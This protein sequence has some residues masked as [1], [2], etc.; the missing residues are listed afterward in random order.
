MR[1]SQFIILF[2][3]IFTVFGCTKVNVKESDLQHLYELEG[4]TTQA[5]DQFELSFRQFIRIVDESLGLRLDAKFFFKELNRK[6]SND[7]HLTSADQQKMQDDLTAYRNNHSNL[8]LVVQ[9]FN[10][11]NAR[12]I[13]IIFPSDRA[14]EIIEN[15][16]SKGQIKDVEL[17][18]NPNDD[19]GRLVILEIKMWLA[20]KL[21]TMDNYVVILVRYMKKSELRRQFDLEN[22]DP[23]GKKFL[24]DMSEEITDGDKYSNTLK[25]IKLVNQILAYEQ[26]HPSGI[27]AKNKENLYLNTL[28]EGSYAYHRIPELSYFDELEIE[29][30]LVEN[31]FYDDIGGLSSDATNSI[32]GLF[33]NTIGLYEERKGKLN[34][35]P[36]AEQSTITQEMQ[37]LDILFEKTPFR[38]TDLFIPG[39]YGHVAIWVGGKKDIPEL[40]RLG[41]WQELPG[42]E[43]KARL[44]FGYVGP[45]FQKLIEQNMSIIEALRRGVEANT[46]ENFLNIDDLAVIRNG[47]LT[48]DQKRDYLLRAFSQIGKE[49]DFNFDIETN[50]TIVCSELI[51][52][53]YDDFNWP[54]DKTLGRYSVSPDHI[55]ALALKED[56]PF[57]PVLIYHDGKKLPKNE[58]IKNFSLLLQGD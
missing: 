14:S 6:L 42:I 50:E 29:N 49:Y 40:K 48:D 11:Y 24:E 51:F 26:K 58:N 41:V 38:L 8:E 32:S 9:N 28:I 16:N 27:L 46:F 44:N 33:G 35:M 36:L 13:K 19:L 55:A 12:D 34:D 15:V 3:I 5:M 25:S 37:L 18:I 39:H 31:A 20:S 22:I 17:Y 4:D 45:S 43:R 21:I 54:V 1:Q 52:I 53:V 10:S 56:D 23:E 2:T 7:M 57:F 47:A 30:D